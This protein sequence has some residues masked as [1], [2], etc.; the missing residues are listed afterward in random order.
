MQ[1][2]APL[3]LAAL[4][5]EDLAVI[6]AHVQD[7]V[8]M[9]GDLHWTPA[10]HR[11]TLAMNRFAW[12]AGPAGRAKSWQRRR[13]VL[14]FDRVLAAQAQC[15]RRD[16]PDAV[17]ELL[18]VTFEPTDAPAGHVVLAFAGGGSLRL[19]VEC[20]E[21]RLA[22]LGAAWQTKALPVHDLSDQPPMESRP[23][24]DR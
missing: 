19:A 14:Q 7:A 11:F 17:L 23:V 4:D 12:E 24:A 13:A 16:R 5:E 1:P 18:A 10:S 3:R 22:D 9:V 20:I 8:L 2:A 21:A 15:I 6:S